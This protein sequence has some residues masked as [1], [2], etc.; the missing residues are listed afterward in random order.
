ME[1][2]GAVAVSL[3]RGLSHGTQGIVTENVWALC[4]KLIYL[5][6]ELR[7]EHCE[8]PDKNPVEVFL[9]LFFLNLGKSF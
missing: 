4:K 2:R 9:F 7:S 8:V 6:G 3:Q 1:A 5:E